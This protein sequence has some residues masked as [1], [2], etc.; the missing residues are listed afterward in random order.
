MSTDRAAG[1]QLWREPA[2]AVALVVAVVVALGFGLIVPV[3]PV[4]ALE[5]GVGLFAATA[6]VSSFAAVRLVSNPYSGSLID[7]IGARRGV[8]YGALIVAFS[9]LLTGFAKSY[10]QL[11]VF[12]GAGGFGSALFF[13]ALLSLV[14]R[15]VPAG[16]RGRAVGLLQGGFLFGMTV[17][18]L[19]GGMLAAPL[20]LR[21]PFL[22]YALFCGAAGV[23]GLR[24]LPEARAAAAADSPV[25]AADSP[26]APDP[27]VA[28]EQA[29]AGEPV[30]SGRGRTTGSVPTTWRT[31]RRLCA[32]PTFTA[33][34]VMMAASRWAATGVRFSLVPLFGEQV[35]GVGPFLLGASLTVGAVSHLLVVWPAG[36]V[37]DTL[38]RRALAV[39]AYFFFALVAAAVGLATTAVAY[40]V[41]LA[42]YGVGTGLT[43]V[44]PAAVAGDVVPPDQTGTGIGVLNTAGD[45]GSVLG[46]VVSGFL[47][48]VA[49]YGWGFGVSALLLGVAG[50]FAVRMRETLPVRQSA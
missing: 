13:N 50:V 27:R 48:Q 22:I 41:V 9:S 23:V 39:P 47:A 42:L 33:A 37:A 31:A 14:V 7:R 24:W 45:I 25:A 6:V 21:W 16:Q 49:G 18:P 8:G 44:T 5:F 17:G 30:F 12:R 40:L 34:L 19:V 32:D 3:L 29:V 43:S 28:A 35:V 1:N 10:A 11:V 2:L 4:F 26:L 38:G 20:G 46:P 15:S 36:K